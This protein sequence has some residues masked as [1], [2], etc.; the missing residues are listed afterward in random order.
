MTEQETER[1]EKLKRQ[2]A[3]AKSIATSG[4]KMLNGEMNADADLSD[5]K[6]LVKTVQYFEEIKAIDK[7][8]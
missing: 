1:Y 7:I 6:T 8:E 3:K 2:V 5:P 4:L